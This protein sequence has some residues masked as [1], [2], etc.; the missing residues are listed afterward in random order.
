MVRNKIRRLG[1]DSLEKHKISFYNYTNENCVRTDLYLKG[2]ISSKSIIQ[3][4]KR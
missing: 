4:G 3:G 1:V 2:C